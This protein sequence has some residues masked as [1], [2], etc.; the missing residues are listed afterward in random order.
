[1]L[2]EIKTIG[3]LMVISFAV[4]WTIVLVGSILVF[5]AFGV[6]YEM[7]MDRKKQQQRSNSK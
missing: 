4:V 2:R 7:A 1:M 3:D 6:L 5:T